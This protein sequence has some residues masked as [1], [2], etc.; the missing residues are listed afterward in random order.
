MSIEGIINSSINIDI[1]NENRGLSRR[2]ME[3]VFGHFTKF[4][5]R[6]MDF[7]QNLIPGKRTTHKIQ[8]QKNR[9]LTKFNTRKMDYSQNSI[10]EK[11]T[12]HKIQ[13]QKH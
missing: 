10:P 9:L 7:S 5:V 3:S 13:Y 2:K 12:T 8:Y 1:I 4:N 11:R 6:K